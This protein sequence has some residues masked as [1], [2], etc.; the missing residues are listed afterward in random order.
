[1]VHTLRS[2]FDFENEFVSLRHHQESTWTKFHLEH[3]K[4]AIQE[5]LS[6]HFGTAVT[7]HQNKKGRFM[8]IPDIS[9]LTILS[10][11]SLQ[12]IS[13]WFDGMTVEETRRRFRATIEIDGVEP[14]WEDHLFSS[15][16]KGIEFKIGEVTLVGMS[17]RARCIV[18]TR[19]PETGEVVHGFTKS[20]VRHRAEAL[21]DFSKL[22]EY[23]HHYYLTVNC[24]A[25]PSEIGKWIHVGDELEIIREKV[26]Y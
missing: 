26:F 14:F 6:A 23:G 2:T 12:T 15:E 13:T 16:G 9:G 25:P 1:L 20:F 11:A 8:D 4:S 10:K 21:P 19:N 22:K 3:D 5:Y 18:P 24:Y 17:P 7:L